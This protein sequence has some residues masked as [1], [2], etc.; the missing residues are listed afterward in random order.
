[1][2]ICVLIVHLILHLFKSH[3]AFIFVDSLILNGE[4]DGFMNAS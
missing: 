2:I 3:I 1:M 4:C